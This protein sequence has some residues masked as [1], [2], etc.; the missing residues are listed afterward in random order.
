LFW[1]LVGRHNFYLVHPVFSSGHHFDYDRSGKVVRVNSK[2]PG[3][4]PLPLVNEKKLLFLPKKP[5]I[6]GK[7]VLED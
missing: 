4:L 6:Q 3:L 2:K 5:K 1:V 7:I